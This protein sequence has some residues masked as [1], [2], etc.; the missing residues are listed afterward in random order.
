[1]LRQFLF[2]ISSLF[3]HALAGLAPAGDAPSHDAL[4][5]TRVVQLVQLDEQQ[6]FEERPLESEAQVS[7]LR[8]QC[9]SGVAERRRSLRQVSFR[10]SYFPIVIH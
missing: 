7:T 2:T 9:R 5:D 1:M 10:L 6:R 4:R 8:A 3:D